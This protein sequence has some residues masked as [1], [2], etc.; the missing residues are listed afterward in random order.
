MG[1]ED[2]LSSVLQQQF[3]LIQEMRSARGEVVAV[4]TRLHMR[5]AE[6]EQQEQHA[7][8]QHEEAL[9]EEDPQA[10]ALREWPERTRARIVELNASVGELATAEEMVSERIR[11]A[12]HAVEDFRVLQPQLVARVAAARNAGVGREV[13]DT[14]NDALN[15]VELV[16]DSATDEDPNGPLRHG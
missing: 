16:L 11:A 6:L 9:A 4:R 5:I 14:L 1:L 12:E 2:R 3:A 15:Y 10:E 8:K 7:R 13:F